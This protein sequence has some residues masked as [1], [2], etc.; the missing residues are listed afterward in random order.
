MLLHAIQFMY[1]IKMIV[2]INLTAKV[3]VSN[4]T[5]NQRFNKDI[6]VLYYK[7]MLMVAI[8]Q[9]VQKFKTL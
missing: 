3:T 7:K 2:R 1:M 5:F 6:F 8:A 9:Y 4:R